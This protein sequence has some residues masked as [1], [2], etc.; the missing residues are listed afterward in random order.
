[1]V[2][3]HCRQKL[4][5]DDYSLNILAYCQEYLIYHY[6]WSNHLVPHLEQRHKM[7]HMNFHNQMNSCHYHNYVNS[8][9][10]MNSLHYVRI[11]SSYEF[12]LCWCNSLFV[13]VLIFLHLW[14][15]EGGK[16][17]MFVSEI[18]LMRLELREKDLFALLLCCWQLHCPMEVAV[19]KLAE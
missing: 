9:I 13:G 14:C 6:Y 8:Y 17:V 19:V 11:Y 16:T 7:G 18:V 1:M 12:M 15:S 4:S 10:Q 2:Y 5:Y 3:L